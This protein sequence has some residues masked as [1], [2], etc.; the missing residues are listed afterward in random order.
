MARI[1][2]L[3]RS[4]RDPACDPRVLSSRDAHPRG[5]E[6]ARRI[7][8]TVVPIVFQL[9]KTSSFALQVVARH[10]HVANRLRHT[11][12][13]TLP[14]SEYGKR[15]PNAKQGQTEQRARI[16]KARLVPPSKRFTVGTAANFR[17]SKRS[18]FHF[19]RFGFAEVDY[20]GVE[21]PLPGSAPARRARIFC[22]RK[23]QNTEHRLPCNWFDFRQ[24]SFLNSV[25]AF[26]S[27]SLRTYW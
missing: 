23:P 17:W 26:N 20:S 19:L 12:E 13:R 6:A 9:R 5:I 2:L 21:T 1:T 4:S 27:S 15:E 8:Q 16:E 18:V 25:E 14:R 10:R 7:R 22:F 3:V 11:R 24:S